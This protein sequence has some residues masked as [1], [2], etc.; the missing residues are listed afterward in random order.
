MLMRAPLSIIIPTLNAGGDLTGT[1]AALMPGLEAGLVRELIV[2]DGGST[3]GTRVIA[4]DAG[5]T[6]IT[7]AT[8][9]GGQLARG[10]DAAQGDWLLFIHADSW[11]SPGWSAPVGLHMSINNGNAGVFRLAFRAHGFNARFVAGWANFRTRLFGL[12]YGDQCLLISRET[13]DNI[14]GFQ[15]IP[16][17][18]D[19]A[20]A[21]ALRGKITVLDHVVVTGAERYLDGGWYRRGARNL[22]ILLRYILGT[23]PD[24]LVKTYT[25]K[26]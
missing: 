25:K 1:L 8:G 23:A 13:Y 14:G 17:M 19:V 7:G 16:L 4:E 21:R 5:A 18:E 22:L 15:D 11:L 9:R 26:P 6:F 24:R 20:I 2:S 10:A 12:P 3:D